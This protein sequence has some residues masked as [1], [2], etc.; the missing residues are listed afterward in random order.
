MLW[1][2][3]AQILIAVL[4]VLGVGVGITTL[5]TP[6]VVRTFLA[7]F[8]PLWSAIGT[9]F[10]YFIFAVAWILTPLLNWIVEFLRGQELLINP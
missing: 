2:R 3:L 6:E 7:F 1:S 4:I 9:L 5:V 10:V 8:S